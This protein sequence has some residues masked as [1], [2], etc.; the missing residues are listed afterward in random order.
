MADI[1]SEPGPRTDLVDLGLVGA[2]HDM[3]LNIEILII[4]FEYHPQ[5]IEPLV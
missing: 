4:A 2:E 1:R 3:R 5:S